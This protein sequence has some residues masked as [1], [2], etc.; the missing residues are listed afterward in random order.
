MAG[1]STP[2]GGCIDDMVLL[3]ALLRS[4]RGRFGTESDSGLFRLEHGSDPGPGRSLRRWERTG[5]PNRQPGQRQG[6]DDD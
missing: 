3:I 2:P 5:G 4:S 6:D 1:S